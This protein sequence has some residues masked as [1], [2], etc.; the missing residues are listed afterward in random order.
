MKRIFLTALFYLLSVVRAY[1]AEDTGGTMN[2]ETYSSY[3]G[4][5]FFALIFAFF[6]F[7]IYFAQRP[8]NYVPKVMV[9][10]AVLA[11]AGNLTAESMTAFNAVYYSVLALIVLFIITFIYLLA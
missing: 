1:S 4:F 3:L 8:E 2:M 11:G 5:A 6:A 10:K 7:F 9:K